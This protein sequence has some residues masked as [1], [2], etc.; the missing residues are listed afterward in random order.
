MG[1]PPRRRTTESY[2]RSA[3]LWNSQARLFQA[4][5]GRRQRVFCASLADVFDDQVDPAWR[6]DLFN[7]IRECDQ[8]DWQ[9][10]TKRPQNIRKMLP[11]DW[12]DGYIQFA[13]IHY[14]RA[15]P[16]SYSAFANAI[17][18]N[19]KSRA[20]QGHWG[21]DCIGK[22][23]DFKFEAEPQ[24]LRPS[25]WI[26]FFCGIEQAAQC[27]SI[28]RAVDRSNRYGG[29]VDCH[30][31]DFRGAIAPCG[32]GKDRIPP[33]SRQ[34]MADNT[35]TDPPYD[36]SPLLLHSY[37]CALPLVQARFSRVRPLRSVA[38]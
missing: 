6:A 27:S 21:L 3:L 1:Q 8:L 35:L 29:C 19:V 14:D 13:S 10:L 11:A 22:W 12:G 16:Q 37:A 30:S 23:V 32:L 34:K 31:W 15:E 17:G 33:P 18:K 24:G 9:L 28:A 20:D 2:W 4:K 26:W 7:L 5:H 38:T 36:L 25:L